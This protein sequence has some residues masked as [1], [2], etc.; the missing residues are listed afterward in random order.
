MEGNRECSNVENTNLCLVLSCLSRSLHFRQRRQRATG[1]T[2]RECFG[3]N[4]KK[5]FF[6]NLWKLY[7]EKV[8]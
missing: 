8:T 3:V 5:E 1:N 4:K 7:S 2:V 6:F